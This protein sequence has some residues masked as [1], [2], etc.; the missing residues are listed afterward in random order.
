MREC[1]QT[2]P[3]RCDASGD[4][5]EAGRSVHAYA[6]SVCRHLGLPHRAPR[7]AGPA[8]RRTGFC[9]GC[10]CVPMREATQTWMRFSTLHLMPM[11]PTRS[12]RSM[13]M[14]TRER[15]AELVGLWRC[16][17]GGRCRRR[18]RAARHRE[19]RHDEPKRRLHLWPPLAHPLID[20]RVSVS[21]ACCKVRRHERLLPRHRCS[22]SMS[23]RR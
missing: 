1:V 22:H 11:R 23:P 9:D 18:H 2:R 4:D 10:L 8:G 6:H 17:L 5:V 15:V 16:G 12:R 13:R 21:Y 19:R 3:R 20:Q 14:C 7:L